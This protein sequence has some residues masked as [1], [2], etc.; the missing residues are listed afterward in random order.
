[1]R[2]GR[3]QAEYHEPKGD[4]T[5]LDGGFDS[6]LVAAGVRQLLLALLLDVELDHPVHDPPCQGGSACS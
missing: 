5:E 2:A 3:R 6:S 1:M 4:E